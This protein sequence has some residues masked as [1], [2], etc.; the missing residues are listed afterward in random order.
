MRDVAG[1]TARPSIYLLMFC[2]KTSTECSPICS[3]K[4]AG[5]ARQI[6]ILSSTECSTFF[7]IWLVCPAARRHQIHTYIYLSIYLL[8]CLTSGSS[9]LRL[10]D[11]N[12][13]Y[14]SIDVRI[15]RLARCAS[16]SLTLTPNTYEYLCMYLAS[17]SS[18]KRLANSKYIHIYIYM[19]Q[20]NYLCMYLASGLFGV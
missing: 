15:W 14:I 3:T 18:R 6:F 19:Y 16:G 13:H 5:D 10:A 20:S 8:E 12:I 17:G 1:S 2:L 7:G 4:T 9:L 11:T